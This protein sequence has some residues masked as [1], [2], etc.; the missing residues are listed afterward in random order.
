[1]AA[2]VVPRARRPPPPMYRLARAFR[3]IG[4]LVLVLVV[5]FVATAAYSAYEVARTG[6]SASSF[7]TQFAPNNTLEVEGQFNF[8]NGGF[9]PIADLSLHLLV[10][11]G[12]GV[13]LGESAAGPKSFAAGASQVFPIDFFLPIVATGA[14]E[15]LL[16]EDQ[17]LQVG[18]WANLTY[19]YLFPISVSFDSNRSWGAPF[20][21]FAAA[22]GTPYTAGGTVEIPV[23]VTFDN[24]A[25]FA[26]D[27]TL[28]L[29]IESSAHVACGAGSFALDVPPGGPYDQTTDIGLAAGCSPAGGSVV[30]TYTVQGGAPISLPPEPIP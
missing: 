23:T 13:Y 29:T 10:R 5:L 11:N 27:G 24:H 26:D 2:Q 25:S 3:R 9:Y 16:T 21:N 30:S 12:T 17:T 4:T 14:A 19:A 28:A 7:T 1:V 8:S 20:A 18:A 15:S 6:P 22:P